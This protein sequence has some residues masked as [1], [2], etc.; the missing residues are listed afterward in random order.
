MN[1]NLKN[2]PVKVERLSIYHGD[3]RQQGAVAQRLH[4]FRGD[5]RSSEM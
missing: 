3:S 5:S 4:S 2:A 1:T